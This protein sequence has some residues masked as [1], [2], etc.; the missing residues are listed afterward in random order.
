MKIVIDSHIPF[1]KG[2]LEPYADVVYALPEDITPRLVKDADALLVRTRTRINGNLLQGSKCRFVATATIGMDHFDAEW[3]R[4]AGVTAVNAPGCNA[5]AVAQYVFA[6]IDKLWRKPLSDTTIAVVGVGNVG[7]IVERWARGL[8]M[9]VML[10]DPPRRE[11]E[12]T[13]G[14]STLSQA[15]READII[16]FHTPLTRTGR[17]ATLHL[18]DEV[19]FASLQN[20]P[21]IVNAARGA[22]VDNSA[23]LK[24]IE[25]GL[26][27]GAAIDVWEGEP[28]IRLDM[29]EKAD[30]ATPHI[31]GYSMDGKIRATQMVLDSL[32]S[33][34][35]LP[36]LKAD[37]RRACSV[38]E[39]VS[40]DDVR[41]SYDIMADDNLMRKSL[42][43]ALSKEE[44]ARTF[45]NLRDFY[46]LRDE[47]N[48][49]KT[50]NK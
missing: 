15:A 4:N 21:L 22:V 7:G 34:F 35:G 49:E 48:R 43:K 13:S 23:W 1:I 10:V 38:P 5:P 28:G 26:I 44:V 41:A 12:K 37:S 17:H 30:I 36:E 46:A 29:L 2:V 16:T 3:C 18:A 9:N 42:T 40:M 27:S 11:K 45:E 19:F 39:F 8:N 24:A 50:N 33:H 20:K 6:A 31:A 25:E 47:I 14:W 32:T